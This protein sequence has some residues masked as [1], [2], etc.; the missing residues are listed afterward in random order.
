[1]CVF[2]FFFFFFFYLFHSF[3]D[4]SSLVRGMIGTRPQSASGPLYEA[5]LDDWE[6]RDPA[7]YPGAGSRTINAFAPFAYDVIYVGSRCGFS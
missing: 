5:F 4:F 1:V 3:C 7:V 2:F 6:T